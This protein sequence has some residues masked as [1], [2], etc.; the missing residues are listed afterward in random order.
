MAKLREK[1][2]IDMLKLRASYGEIGDDHINGRWLYRDTWTNEDSFRPG[3]SSSGNPD[4]P[5]SSYIWWRMAQE[6]NPNLHWEKAKKLDLAVDFGF[7]GGLITG[8]FD[9]FHEN[10]SD[11]LIAGADR[12]VPSYY[13]GNAPVANLGKVKSS[14]Y[15]FD[16]RFNKQLN[17]NLRL[18]GNVA[19]THATNK[20]EERD[21]P[22]LTPEYQKRAGKTID[23]T[24]TYLNKG[25]YN[26]WDELYYHE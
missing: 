5:K 14:G 7:L 8:S 20:I 15:E 25:Y 16:I 12:A 23:Q 17:K 6:G 22:Q 24:Y 18:W 2:I 13:G 19:F 4:F 26:N 3:I 10:R 1:H 9:Y 11:I 21:D